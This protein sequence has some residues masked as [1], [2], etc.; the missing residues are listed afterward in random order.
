[1]APIPAVWNPVAPIQ[2]NWD[3]IKPWHEGYGAV[4][5]G[6]GTIFAAA[7]AIAL[8]VD[9][10]GKPPKWPFTRDNW[11]PKHTLDGGKEEVTE[12]QILD[13]E[14]AEV[15]ETLGKRSLQTEELEWYHGLVDEAITPLVKRGNGIIHQYR[16]SS[17]TVDKGKKPKPKKGTTPEPKRSNFG[18]LG[19]DIKEVATDLIDIGKDV[20]KDLAEAFKPDS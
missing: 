2:N 14:L 15:V 19:D 18:I 5:G 11:N 6:L 3:N 4:L 16:A 10:K 17:L 20:W 7:S 8:I 9:H 1:M 13:D 12:D